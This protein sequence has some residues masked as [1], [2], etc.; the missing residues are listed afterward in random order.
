MKGM[1]VVGEIKV[2]LSSKFIA[3]IEIWLF[4]YSS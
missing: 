2:F 3:S 4:A 1:G